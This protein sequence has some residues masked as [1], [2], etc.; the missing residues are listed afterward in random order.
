MTQQD[1]AEL[2]NALHD[3]RKPLILFNIWDAGSA[4]A[5]AQAGASAIATGSWSVAAAHGYPDGEALPLDLALANL[6]RIVA[7]VDLPVSVDLE[8]GYGDDPAAVARTVAQAIAAGAIGCNLEDSKDEHRF[9]DISEQSKR[10]RAA[11]GAAEAAGLRFFINARVDLFLRSPASVH[12]RELLEQGLERATAYVEA[13]AS[14]IF[15]PS[16]ADSALIE[17]CCE[18]CPK[19]VNI[20]AAPGGPPAEQLS[21]LGVARI[22]HAAGPYRRATMFLEEEARAIYFGH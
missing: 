16:L 3:A 11:R 21:A 14:G 5:V 20:M 22:S 10:L 6:A 12:D 4:K 18:T 8:R 15:V 2:F 7:A 17:S 9:Y 19:P 1:K 13:G